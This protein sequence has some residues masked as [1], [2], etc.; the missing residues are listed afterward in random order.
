MRCWAV[1]VRTGG[2]GGAPWEAPGGASGP[3]GRAV[4]PRQHTLQALP[5]SWASAPGQ[6]WGRAWVGRAENLAVSRHPPPCADSHAVLI[7]GRGNSMA[8]PQAPPVPL[9]RCLHVLSTFTPQA[10]TVLAHG[11]CSGNPRRMD[12]Q[13]RVHTVRPQPDDSSFFL[14][15]VFNYF[16]CDYITSLM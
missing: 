9:C 3:R 11:T 4:W 8:Q 14:L 7:P 6:V 16:C 1:E 15:L 13:T 5:G 12:Q 10:L 2:R